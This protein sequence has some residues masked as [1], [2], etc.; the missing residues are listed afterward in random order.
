MRDR[1][2]GLLINIVILHKTQDEDL[3]QVK[4]LP[5]KRATMPPKNLPRPQLKEQL[6]SL[7][8]DKLRD[9]LRVKK[10]YIKGFST[11][12][13]NALVKHIIDHKID[14]SDHIK[15]KGI[16][17]N[18]KKETGRMQAYQSTE[19]MSDF[20]KQVISLLARILGVLEQSD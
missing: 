2:A 20:E 17:A 3:L 6:S 16:E 19:K 11:L 8:N 4:Y 9:I 18:R 7:T 10:P 14:C 12:K 13:K 5:L 15:A 1:R